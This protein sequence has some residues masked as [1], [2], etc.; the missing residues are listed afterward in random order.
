MIHLPVKQVRLLD[1][2]DVDLF[3]D[4]VSAFLRDALLLELVGEL[5]AIGIDDEGFLFGLVRVRR[6]TKTVRQTENRD[7]RYASRRSL[8]ASYA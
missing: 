2:L 6:L 4:P 3:F 8:S 5:Q 1:G 7:G